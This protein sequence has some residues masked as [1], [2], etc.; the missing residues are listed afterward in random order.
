M[1]NIITQINDDMYSVDD[2]TFDETTTN[3]IK[4]G[5]LAKYVSATEGW[6]DIAK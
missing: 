4:V 3:S 2:Q 5:K 6:L 1:K